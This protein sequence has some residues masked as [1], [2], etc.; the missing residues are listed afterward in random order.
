MTEQDAYKPVVQKGILDSRFTSDPLLAQ[1]RGA[2][3]REWSE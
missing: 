1:V 3:S 2:M